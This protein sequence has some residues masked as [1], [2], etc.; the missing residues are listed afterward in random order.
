MLFWLRDTLPWGFDPRGYAESKID[1]VRWETLPRSKGSLIWGV[2]SIKDFLETCVGTL[3]TTGAGQ[4]RAVTNRSSSW[5]L[6]A[7]WIGQVRAK[8]TRL[9]WDSQ[10][11]F[12]KEL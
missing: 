7:L 5:G 6:K 1:M 10:R 8:I 2:Q 11:K 12:K 4:L 9:C 3:V